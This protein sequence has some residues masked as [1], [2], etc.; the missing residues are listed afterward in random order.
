LGEGTVIRI[1][2]AGQVATV[3]NFGTEQPLYDVPDAGLIQGSDGNF[4]GTTSG[5]GTNGAGTV[6]KITPGGVVTLLHSFN[7]SGD[8]R[9]PNA[10]LM[11]ASDG[12]FYGTTTAGGTGT[13]LGVYGTVFKISPSGAFTLLHTFTG[14]GNDGN[15][16]NYAA[17]IQGAD[18]NLYGTTAR[19]GTSNNGTIF[20]VTLAG[21]VST[22]YSFSVTD[23][24]TPL[25]GMILGKDGNLY[26]TTSAGGSG[27]AGTIFRYSTGGSATQGSGTPQIASV[28]KGDS[29]QTQASYQPGRD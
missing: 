12:N 11:L 10:P 13:P 2:L 24:A 15:Q 18:G 27:F 20:K 16:P 8:G 25:G 28:A 26:G 17:L 14:T 19:G 7:I 6:F 29:L 4:Y 9:V 22:V 5:G 1:S 21:T 3:H 23:G